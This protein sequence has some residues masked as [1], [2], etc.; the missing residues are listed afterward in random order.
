M[1]TLTLLVVLLLTVLSHQ[2]MATA[3]A[4]RTNA[5]WLAGDC[6]SSETVCR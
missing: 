1:R 5:L 6:T 2:Y 3:R 4:A